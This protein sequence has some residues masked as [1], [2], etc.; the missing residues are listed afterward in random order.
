MELRKKSLFI[1]LEGGE[2]AGKTSLIS[3]LNDALETLD[4]EVVV[5]RE[6]GGTKLGELLRNWLLNPNADTIIGNKAETLLFLAAR[7]QHIEELI[8]PALAKNKIVICDRFNDSTI[9]Y[10][11]GGRQLGMELIQK[12]CDL[13]CGEVKPDITLFLDVNPEVGLSRTKKIAKENA[14]MGEVDRIE[15]EKMKF[16]YHVRETF[17]KIAQQD[18]KRFRI[19]DAHQPQEIVFEQALHIIKS[20]L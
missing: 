8:Q 1:T 14:P 19:L 15:A 5:T 4:F 18:P 7:A 20:A 10:Q 6:P 9:A 17:Q 2:G 13:A 12:L 16:H 11:G 3:K